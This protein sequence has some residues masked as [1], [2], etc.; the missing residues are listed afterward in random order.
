MTAPVGDYDLRGPDFE[1]IL[2]GPVT[3]SIIDADREVRD[4][5]AN[6]FP[7]WVMYRVVLAG[8]THLHLRLRDFC[9]AY[10]IAHCE[11]GGVR[12]G[13]P[14]DEIGC[15]AGWDA[16]YAL[17]H[18]KWL[19]AGQD[20]ADVA[21]VDPKT[22]RKVRAHVYGSLRASMDEYWVRMQVAIRQVAMRER[23]V[24]AVLPASR[25]S[26]GR[27]FD[28]DEDASGTGNFIAVPRGSGC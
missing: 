1:T 19:I 15:L 16:F 18:H 11:A 21:G 27:G 13:L 23:W 22:Y 3:A 8:D 10:A 5:W 2:V 6:G 14:A 20:V 9:V 7:N 28:L 24:Q 25:Y 4:D 12:K 26:E 17:L